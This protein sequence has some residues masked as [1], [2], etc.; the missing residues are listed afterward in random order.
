VDNG[1]KYAPGPDVPLW[2]RRAIQS[3]QK[4]C[5]PISYAEPSTASAEEKPR[6]RY[7]WARAAPRTP[8]Q[9]SN[10]IDDTTRMPSTTMVIGTQTYD[11]GRPF[12]RVFTP[13]PVE[14]CT[15]VPIRLPKPRYSLHNILQWEEGDD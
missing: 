7:R 9:A 4:Q 8:A 14:V 1:S 10:R 6:S 15:D 3:T 5:A 2:I 13:R 12:P 11:I